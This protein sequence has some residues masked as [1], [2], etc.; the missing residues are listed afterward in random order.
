VSGA[1]EV[2]SNDRKDRPE[3]DRS[4]GPF[5]L[6][7]DTQNGKIGSE[8][9]KI[10]QVFLKNIDHNGNEISVQNAGALIW[11]ALYFSKKEGLRTYFRRRV[12]EIKGKGMK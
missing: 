9:V 12:L 2:N 5:A 1:I 10:M 6:T 11:K 3:L 4:G 7:A 8:E